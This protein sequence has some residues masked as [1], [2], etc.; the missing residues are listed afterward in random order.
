MAVSSDPDAK[1]GS[2]L[3]WGGPRVGFNSPGLGG[4]GFPVGG[5]VDDWGQFNW[6]YITG[7]ALAPG[8]NPAIHFNTYLNKWVIVWHGWNNKLYISASADTMTWETPRV[9]AESINKSRAWYPTIICANGGHQ[10]C[11]DRGRLYY[12]DNWNPVGGAS[13]VR[14]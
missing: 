3:K 1:A 10:W 11:G 6:N 13:F 4:R 9:L 14:S 2:W 12:A 5:T 7:L 8:A